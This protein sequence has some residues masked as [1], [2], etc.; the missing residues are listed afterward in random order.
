MPAKYGEYSGPKKASVREMRKQIH[1]VWRGVGFGMMILIP[2]ISYAG[3]RVL[4][5]Q[6]IIF[7]R[8][9]IPVDLLAKP[10]EFLYRFFPDS[11]LYIKLLIMFTI[12][13]VLYLIFLIFSSAVTGAFGISEKQDPYYVPPVKRQVRRRPR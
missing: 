8:M 7:S 3:M 10:G 13:F 1:P 4:I 12:M 9:P 6:N 11:M 5:D 2:I